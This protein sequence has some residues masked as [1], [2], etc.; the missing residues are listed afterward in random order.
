MAL[1]GI[2]LLS[3]T[4]CFKED[5]EF[6][7]EVVVDNNVRFDFG[8]ADKT[9]DFEDHI[10]S[11][12]VGIFDGAGNH[13]RT[14][15]LESSDIA[16]HQGAV[17]TLPS[18]S[19]RFVFWANVGENTQ[20]DGLDGALPRVVYSDVRG[21][22][23]LMVGDGDKLF[24]APSSALT[25][26]HRA[27]TMDFYSLVLPV[28]GTHKDV[29]YFTHAH[30]SLEIFVKGLSDSQPFFE[31]EGLPIGS[32][33]FGMQA[34][35]NTKV[36]ASQAA[37]PVE[38]DGEHYLAANFDTFYF[39]DMD[40]IEIVI[41]NGEGRELYRT[42]LADAVAES[43]SDPDEIVIE[44]VLGFID[45]SVEITIPDWSSGDTGID[46]EKEKNR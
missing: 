35:P 19:Y 42:S 21:S 27:P 29:I 38:K 14:E 7:P 34:L 25:R 1:L 46:F 33:H 44:L 8:M 39:D 20:I 15:R 10:S 32:Q 3:L 9:I 45:G 28:G 2:A 26:G 36:V 16:A 41:R 37:V 30:R 6:C 18:G 17:F 31:I 11:V 12:D 13:L 23:I 40:G 43:H 4:G 22:D 24:Y 5:Y